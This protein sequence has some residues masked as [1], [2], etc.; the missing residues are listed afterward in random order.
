[1]VL[2]AAAVLVGLIGGRLLPPRR[3]HQAG[4]RLR[5]WGLLP[6]GL[7]LALAAS[8]LDGTLAVLTGIAGFAALVA[9]TSRN[10]HLAG[11]GVI[12]IGLALNLLGIVVNWGLPVSPRALVEADVVDAEE[13]QGVDLEGYR[14]LETAD[15]PLPILGDAIPLPFG[16]RVVSFGDLI[17][18]FGAASVVAN[19]TRR[20]YRQTR[21]EA[22]AD[23]R[24]WLAPEEV[25]VATQGGP[26]L[27]VEPVWRDD[28]ELFDADIDLGDKPADPTDP[29][30][31]IPLHVA[32]P[33]RTD[34]ATSSR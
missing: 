6:T 29:D 20:R 32:R 10:L 3:R 30:I 19:L 25:A 15:D 18:A 16:R 13:V 7:L 4:V 14:T 9:F 12:T 21:E 2:I 31:T 26:D 1:V 24:H 8:R 23:L 33:R 34:R 28:L 5:W 17:V 22:R 27:G 11:M